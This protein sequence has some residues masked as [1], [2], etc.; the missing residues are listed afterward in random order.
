MPDWIAVVILGIVEGLTEFLPVS[1]TGHLL[2]VQRWFDTPVVKTQLFDVVI[3]CGAMLA[4]LLV[5]SKRAG[6]LIRSSREPA[7]REYLLKLGWAFAITAAGGLVL[8]A[9]HWKLPK[10]VWP[11][12][13]ATL[14]GG[15]VILG[16]E[17]WLRGR[18]TS[19]DMT[20]AAATAAGCAQLLAATCPGTSRS[21]ACILFALAVGINRPAA[22]EFSFL[23]GIPTMFAASGVEIL[24]E[25]KH[26]SQLSGHDWLM[27]GLGSLTAAISAFLVVRWLLRFVQSH[28]F[29]V[30]GWYRIV[31]GTI[32]IAAYGRS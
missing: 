20:W 13:L 21:G 22:T 28:T 9:L 2:I 6:E 29:V 32:L 18:K 14:V 16:L 12:A 4:V 17:W 23:L 24:S 27:V 3:Q 15:F 26:G 10:T 5:F 19:A 25:L 30:F 31:L 8:K 11:V 7:A 1:S